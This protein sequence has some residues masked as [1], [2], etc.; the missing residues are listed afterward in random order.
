MEMMGSDNECSEWYDNNNNGDDDS[1]DDD[2][3][4]I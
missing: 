1:D 4:C 2:D 3:Y